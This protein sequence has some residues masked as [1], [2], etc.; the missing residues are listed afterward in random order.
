MIVLII[1]FAIV[2][3]VCLCVRSCKRKVHVHKQ[4]EDSSSSSSEAEVNLKYPVSGTFITDEGQQFKNQVPLKVDYNT[5]VF[6]GF[7]GGWF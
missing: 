3:L 7:D 4:K 6:G 2:I 5:Y 1:I